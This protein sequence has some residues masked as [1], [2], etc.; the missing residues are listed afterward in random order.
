MVSRQISSFYGRLDDTDTDAVTRALRHEF[1]K[2]D[3]KVFDEKDLAVGGPDAIPARLRNGL[4]PAEIETTLKAFKKKSDLRYAIGSATRDWNDMLY[5]QAW[6]ELHPIAGTHVVGYS[7]TDHGGEIAQTTR[8][9]VVIE[10]LTYPVGPHETMADVVARV[11]KD[12]GPYLVKPDKSKLSDAELESRIRELNQLG[13]NDPVAGL[14]LTLLPEAQRPDASLAWREISAKFGPQ[15]ADALVNALLM[16]LG[17]VALMTGVAVLT[18]GTT[19]GFLVT[20]PLI[21]AAILQSNLMALVGAGALVLG[22][23]KAGIDGAEIFNFLWDASQGKL[24]AADI[25]TRAQ[26]INLGEFVVEAALV[27]ATAKPVL[28]HAA[29]KV[30]GMYGRAKTPAKPAPSQPAE[31][32]IEPQPNRAG[33]PPVPARPAPQEPALPPEQL[34][35]IRRYLVKDSFP[36]DPNSPLP[37]ELAMRRGYNGVDPVYA[38]FEQMNFAELESLAQKG[39]ESSQVRQLAAAFEDHGVNYYD[40]MRAFRAEQGLAGVPVRLTPPR[41]CNYDD[42]TLAEQRQLFEEGRMLRQRQCFNADAAKQAEALDART[43]VDGNPNPNRTPID[44]WQNS[45]YSSYNY[46]RPEGGLKTALSESLGRYTGDVG[47][48]MFSRAPTVEARFASDPDGYAAYQRALAQVKNGNVQFDG[49]LNG[50]LDVCAGHVRATDP[51]TGKEFV[52]DA[53][54]NASPDGLSYRVTSLRF[55]GVLG[56]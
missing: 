36:D 6:V 14:S 38:G 46:V 45:G 39:V 51:V 28:T 10:D 35:K 8:N 33:D 47:N 7:V 25:H 42:L 17:A 50:D 16:T 44:V 22:A 13:P 55:N 15:V 54:F 40:Y 30:P 32:F 52:F 5:N 24:S 48:R 20:T 4:T 41:A 23:G 29:N 26:T 53:A 43:Y 37:G 2:N 49:S 19:S 34:Q 1:D 18:M 56:R 11:R 31:E 12:Y 21:F 9:P 27:G 3:D